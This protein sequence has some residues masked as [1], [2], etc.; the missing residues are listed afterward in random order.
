[1]V[2]EKFR[3][4]ITNGVRTNY[5]ERITVTWTEFGEETGS[6]GYQLADV[7]IPIRSANLYLSLINDGNQTIEYSFDGINLDGDLVPNTSSEA[8]TFEGRSAFKIWF[9]L[10]SAGSAEVRVEAYDKTS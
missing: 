5:F 4:R 10:K 9:R 6:D 1:M 7:L 2:Q 8:L 3:R